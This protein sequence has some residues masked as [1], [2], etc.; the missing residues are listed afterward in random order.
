MKYHLIK[1][2]DFKKLIKSCN[3]SLN[4][5]IMFVN[6]FNQHIQYY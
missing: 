3:K 4:H 1:E 2:F 6:M 5:L